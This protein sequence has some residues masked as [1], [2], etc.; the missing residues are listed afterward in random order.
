[1]ISDG[2]GI[3]KPVPSN[4]TGVSASRSF[5]VHLFSRGVCSMQCYMERGGRHLYSVTLGIIQTSVE[6]CSSYCLYLTAAEFKTRPAE[7]QSRNSAQVWIRRS[8]KEERFII[9]LP[10]TSNCILLSVT[11]L[12]VLGLGITKDKSYL[13]LF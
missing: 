9:L 13:I 2:G 8:H 12:Q 11:V 6:A 1:M 3:L 5:S 4:V 10:F 7:S